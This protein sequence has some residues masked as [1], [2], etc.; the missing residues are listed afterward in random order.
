MKTIEQLKFYA[1]QELMLSKDFVRKFG[2]LNAKSTWEEAT[3]AAYYKKEV[4]GKSKTKA[5]EFRPPPPTPPTFTPLPDE[6]LEPRKTP[7]GGDDF[8]NLIPGDFSDR[9]KNIAIAILNNFYWYFE[10]DPVEKLPFFQE[11]ELYSYSKISSVDICQIE[12]KYVEKAIKATAFIGFFTNKTVWIL[13]IEEWWG[14][15]TYTLTRAR[16]EILQR[17]TQKIVFC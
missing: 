2:S 1:T 16:Q 17:L 8:S 6:K 9:Q 7:N 15:K 13:K 10:N 11:P 12:M 4:S 14:A 3:I 5:V